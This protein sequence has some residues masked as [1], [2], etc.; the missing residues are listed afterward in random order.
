M[1]KKGELVWLL[2]FLIVLLSGSTLANTYLNENSTWQSNLTAV[3]KGA[4]AL[5]D[6]DGDGYSDLVSTGVGEGGIVYSKVYINNGSSLIENSTWQDNLT[7]VTYSSVAFGDVDN[8][9][10]LDLAL[11][12]CS[13]GGGVELCNTPRA[14]IYINNGTSLVDNSTW[15]GDIS[16]VGESSIAFGDVDN[17]GKLDL[18]LTGQTGE[19][20]ISKIYINNGTGFEENS[21]WQ[22]DLVGVD[23]CGIT[24][25]DI[26]NDNKLDFILTGED[27]NYN[28]NTKVYINNGTSFEENSIWQQNLIAVDKSSVSVGDINNDGDLDL[29]LIGCC[30]RHRLYNNSGTTFVETE[31]E[32]PSL[33]Y[34]FVGVMEGSVIWGDYDNDGDLDLIA[35]GREKYTTL[36][37]NNNSDFPDYGDDPESGI[38]DLEWSSLVWGDLDNDSDLDLVIFGYDPNYAYAKIYINNITTS[39]TA[40]NASTDFNTT[41]DNTELT[42][43]WGNASDDETPAAGLYYNLRVGNSSG[44]NR[45]VSGVYGGGDD[46]GYFGNMMQ[47][48]S[49]TLK[50]IDISANE[51]IYWSVQTIDTGLKAGDWS[52]EQN[53]TLPLDITRPEITLNAPVDQFNTTNPV[54]TFNATVYDDTNLTNVSLYGNW[55]GWHTNETNSSGI[56][57]TNYIFTKNLTAYGD[58]VYQWLI[59]AYDATNNSINSSIRTFRIDTTY[60]I[61][62]LTTPANA[63]SWTSSQTV[64]FTYNI[65]DLVIVNCSLII[66]NAVDQTDETI[67][68][69]TSQT[70]SKTLSNGDYDWSVNCTDTVNYRNAS[71]TRTL[72]V[73]YTAPGGG[74]GGGGGGGGGTTTTSET[75]STGTI[76]A[77]ETKTISFTKDLGITDIEITAKEKV[78]DTV[79]VEDITSSPD[80]LFPA[81]TS[82]EGSVYKYLSLTA[83]KVSAVLEKAVVKFKVTKSWLTYNKLDENTVELKRLVGA[84]WESLPTKK[85]GSDKDYF[86]YEAQTSGFSKFAIVGKK[87][88]EVPKVA[89]E[90]LKVE[91]NLTEEV[92][93]EVNV[94]EEVE[95]VKEEMPEEVKEINYLWLVPIITALIIIAFLI[96]CNIKKKGK[97]RK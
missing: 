58:G 54:I 84:A 29:T 51:T 56:N 17:D 48:K 46:N 61:V 32:D 77:G 26:D 12:G 14:F 55:S 35:T 28:K 13:S 41:Y 65:T 24:F 75:K 53:Y 11:T 80:V 89:K 95:E 82:V 62:S 92:I 25:G 16:E 19:G 40:P 78:S 9:G 59:E 93:E 87:K 86:Y 18:A 72:T 36:Y 70:F 96:I 85:A 30:D 52:V 60:P 39:N 97:K 37:V 94:T 27:D 66:N 34:R 43:Q 45:I 2:T 47:R 23:S 73:S 10:D 38:T 4:I 20:R 33:S 8:D 90:E 1:S 91:E 83:S 21:T 64:T 42:L 49:I 68:T 69:G 31:S 76:E 22:T 67:T 44:S 3:Y 74:N 79:R 81:V 57:N 88:V 5:G 71:E 63:S 6:I 15:K 7:A 50:N